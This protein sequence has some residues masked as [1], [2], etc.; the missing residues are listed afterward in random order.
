MVVSDLVFHGDMIL[1]YRFMN[2]CLLKKKPRKLCV[3]FSD[4]VLPLTKIVMKNRVY[5]IVGGSTYSL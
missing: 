2:A 1:G 3:V 5:M 4:D